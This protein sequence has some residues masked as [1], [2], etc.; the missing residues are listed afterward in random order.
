M[1][2][3]A[4]LWIIDHQQKWYMHISSFET[5]HS[6][7][8]GQI[9][10]TH[11]WQ[12]NF[13]QF[14]GSD[15]K[16]WK[17]KTN[18]TEWDLWSAHENFSK[19]PYAHLVPTT[20]ISDTYLELTPSL[21]YCINCFSL[22]L[23][24]Q[25]LQLQQIPSSTNGEYCAT[26]QIS[27]KEKIMGGILSGVVVRGS[28]VTLQ[29]SSH[30]CYKNLCWSN[31]RHSIFHTQAHNTANCHTCQYHHRSTTRFESSCYQTEKSFWRCKHG[32]SSVGG[33]MEKSAYIH[34][35][36]GGQG[37]DAFSPPLPN[38]ATTFSLSSYAPQIQH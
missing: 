19:L 37:F 24:L 15:M 34:A 35:Y 23:H 38:K 32:R 21:T 25:G 28:I 33:T 2:L 22:A 1:L 10:Q 30:F 13:Q 8:S 18:V 5:T 11:P 17:Q 16:T 3:S 14:Q 31:F 6:Q 12:W 20:T 4:N 9:M 29:V 7:W 27:Y 26:L 36:V